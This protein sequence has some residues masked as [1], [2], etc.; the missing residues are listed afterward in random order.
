MDSGIPD[1]FINPLRRDASSSLIERQ[2]Q[3]IDVRE[4]S[5]AGSVAST[6]AHR[7]EFAWLATV[8]LYVIHV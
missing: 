2:L 4:S 5:Q 6:A 1:Y 8:L 3:K 7:Q